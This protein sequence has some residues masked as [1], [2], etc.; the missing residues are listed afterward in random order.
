M[1]C[2]FDRPKGR[3]GWNY[4]NLYPTEKQA[5]RTVETIVGYKDGNREAAYVQV[6][7]PFPEDR[8]VP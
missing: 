2:V 4:F 5:K 7:I 1:F 6:F 8:T 3:G